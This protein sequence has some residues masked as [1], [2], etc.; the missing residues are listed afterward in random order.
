M[1]VISPG[2][3]I[4]FGSKVYFKATTA[5]IH[6]QKFE[7]PAI[8]GRLVGYE[9]TLGYG[10]SGTY[11]VWSLD[12]FTGIDLHQKANAI[13]RRQIMPHLVKELAT[14]EEGIVF[15]RKAE[16]ERANGTLR[17]IAEQRLGGI[18]ELPAEV[19]DAIVVVRAVTGGDSWHEDTMHWPRLHVTPR[20]TRFVPRGT[21]DGPE[22][23]T[24]D[25]S[26]LF[27]DGNC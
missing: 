25:S 6:K 18:L 26:R 20:Q 15:P 22:L 24:L 11:I 23:S 3:L 5:R 21:D 4:P 2:K 7:D 13:N 27:V 16:C 8:V 1:E 19:G 12:D 14:V 17:G 9:T 10:L